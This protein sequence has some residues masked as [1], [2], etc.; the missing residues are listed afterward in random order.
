MLATC[1]ERSCWRQRRRRVL[2]A[3]AAVTAPDGFGRVLGAVVDTEYRVHP[4]FASRT[5]HC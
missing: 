4:L 1:T 3:A 2:A 5:A